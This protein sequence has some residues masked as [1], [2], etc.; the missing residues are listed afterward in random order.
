M[1]IRKY[2]TWAMLVCL[3]T[4]L[5]GCEDEDYDSR[6]P[7]FEDVTFQMLSDGSTTLRTG[8]PILVTAVQ[9]KKGHLLLGTTYKWET[10][11]AEGVTHKPFSGDIYDLVPKNPT[12]T[13]VVSSS[14]SY[15]ITLNASYKTSGAKGMK[16][17]YVETFADENGSAE[18]SVLGAAI[19][20]YE[21][22]L[23]KYFKV[24]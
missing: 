14:G 12:D 3:S 1:N 8:E 23:E 10:S 21:V 16:Q 18:Y 20:H 19:F 13:I 4:C 7:K 17:G 6:P 22:R 2:I 24:K 11:P 5:A 15:K 9:K